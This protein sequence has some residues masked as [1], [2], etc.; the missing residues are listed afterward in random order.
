MPKEAG[1]LEQVS[2]QFNRLPWHDSKFISLELLPYE[3]KERYDLQLNL[4]LLTHSQG[5][6]YKLEDK[7]LLFKECRIIQLDFDMLAVQLIGGDIASA[8]CKTDADDRERTERDKLKDFDL[9]QTDNALNEFLFFKITLIHP[10]GELKV[11]A[12]SFELM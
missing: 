1:Q 12:K 9:P 11:F 4:K 6:E 5:G 7:K 2:D 8:V 3:D 10:G